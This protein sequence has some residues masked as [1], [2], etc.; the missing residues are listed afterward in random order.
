MPRVLVKCPETGRVRATHATLSPRQFA[1]MS[2]GLVYWCGDCKRAHEASRTA[3]W[4][5]GFEAE[6]AAA[7]D[8]ATRVRR[9]RLHSQWRTYLPSAADQVRR[10]PHAHPVAVPRERGS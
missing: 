1:K 2:D 8:G 10:S 6:G 5:E 7:A 9:S 4:L 3:L